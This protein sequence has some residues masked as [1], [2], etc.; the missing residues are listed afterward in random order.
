MNEAS[1]M[2]TDVVVDSGSIS[3]D[4]EFCGRT[5][6]EDSEQAGDWEPGELEGL[7]KRA[8]EEPDKVI[9]MDSVHWGTIDGKQAVVGCPCNALRKY[10]DFIWNHR[11]M[12]MKYI[13]ARVK[14]IVERALED[15]GSADEVTADIQR[16]EKAQTTVRCPNCLKFVSELAM[17]E[18]GMCVK[19]WQAAEN[20]SKQEQEERDR[21]MIAA[22]VQDSEDNLPF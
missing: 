4:C 15:E 14:D 16:A 1:P 5:F 17:T 9:G 12:I 3:V 6:F 10:E 21:Q 22:P 20:K 11:R 2:F 13:S 19:C 8:K 7:R 18:G